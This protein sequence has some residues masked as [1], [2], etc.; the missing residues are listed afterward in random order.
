[1][2]SYLRSQNRE[3]ATPTK[4]LIGMW[5]TVACFGLMALAGLAGGDT[6]KVSPAW[7]LGAYVLL[8]LA[9]I[10]LSPMGLSL[11]ARMAPQKVRGVMMGV[12][13]LT[14]SG[15]GYFAGYLGSEYAN[16]PHSRFF[17]LVAGLAAVAAV[18]LMLLL[19]QFKSIFARSLA[20]S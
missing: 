14:L 9:E 16:M 1:L 19:R 5:I 13:F 12:W 3:P 18:V 4:L 10:C 17:L 8:S 15:G 2:W 6:G 7:L 11:V 20:H